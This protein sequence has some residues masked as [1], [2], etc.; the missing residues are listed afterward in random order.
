MNVVTAWSNTCRLIVA[1]VDF[2]Q[3]KLAL[4]V[5]DPIQIDS[6]ARDTK[7]IEMI[8]S[9][10][11]PIVGGSLKNPLPIEEELAKGGMN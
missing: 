7:E 9:W 4:H 10:M 6:F 2:R 8:L 11:F 5:A 3:I 1:E